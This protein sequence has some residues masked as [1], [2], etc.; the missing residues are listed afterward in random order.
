MLI[1]ALIFLKLDWEKQR[2]PTEHT[3]R[4]SV[5]PQNVFEKIVE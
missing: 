2:K 5:A 3:D 4:I 1:V